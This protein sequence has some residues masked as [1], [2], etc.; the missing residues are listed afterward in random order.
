MKIAQVTPYD[1]AHPGG[2]A[3]HIQHLKFELNELGH[4]VKIIAPR[5]QSG[6]LE[7]GKDFYGVGRTVAIPGN[8]SRVRLTFD[9]TL[10]SAVKEMLQREQFDVI[11]LH[12]PL[13]P[14]LPYM[15]LLN[16]RAVNV[17]T[18]HAYRFSNPWYSAFKPY[19]SFVL[20]R[21]DAR[22]AVSEAAREF[23]GQYF[24]GPYTIIPNGIDPARF[25]NGV[26]PF[27]WANDGVPRILFVGRFNES[28]KGFKYILKAMPLIQQQ[29]PTARLMVV[30]PGDPNR[31]IGT[32]ERNRIR[33]VDFVGQVSKEDLPRYYASCTM[34]VAPS[35]ERESFGIILLEAM[36]SGKPLVATNIPGY[37]GVVRNDHDCL[38]VPAQDSQAMALATVRVLADPDLRSRLIHNGLATAQGYAWPKVASRVLDT[39]DRALATAGQAKWR[40]E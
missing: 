33:G 26:E 19:M 10:Y 35:I 11:H 31:L 22:I 18:F 17:A 15:V 5:S 36:A 27:P 37:A 2:V 23:V 34:V 32:M 7:V 1:F 20:G 40:Q 9:V 8:K 25:S 28:R 12:E 13:T 16:S 14:V 29:F 21:L 6:G 39:Y 24:E 30:G 38:M 4:Q 3:E